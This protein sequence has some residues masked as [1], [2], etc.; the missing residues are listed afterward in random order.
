[1][2]GVIRFIT[3]VKKNTFYIDNPKYFH[4][5]DCLPELGGGADGAGAGPQL[6]DQRVRRELAGRGPGRRAG[7]GVGGRGRAHRA[8]AGRARARAVAHRGGAVLGPAAPGAAERGPAGL[9]GWDAAGPERSLALY[10][11]RS[12]DDTNS[13]LY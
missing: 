11:L 4:A 5:R 12:A 9:Q 7:R 10:G 8:A 6:R 3:L 13:I 1:M 2:S